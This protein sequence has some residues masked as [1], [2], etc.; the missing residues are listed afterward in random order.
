M[1][2]LLKKYGI[3]A[4]QVELIRLVAKHPIFGANDPSMSRVTPAALRYG[5]IEQVWLDR[6]PP[7]V[8]QVTDYHIGAERVQRNSCTS[9]QWYELT[10]HAVAFME[11]LEPGWTYDR[12]S[13]RWAS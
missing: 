11:E 7:I 12:P 3:T 8:R 6:S 1:K 9:N 4:K 10:A 2:A 5:V 13:A